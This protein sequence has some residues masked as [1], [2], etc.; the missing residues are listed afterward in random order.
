MNSEFPPPNS[1]EELEASITAMLLGELPSDKAFALGRAIEQ[2]PHLAESYAR[3]KKTIGLIETASKNEPAADATITPPKLTGARR[4]ELL[5][6]FKTVAPKEFVRKSEVKSRW[7][8]AL[9]VTAAILIL[10]SISIPN[11][12]KA[13]ST[14]Q[15]NAIINNL[16]Q[17]DG[18]K[19]QWALEHKK[20]DSDTPTMADLTPYLRVKDKSIAGERYDIGQVGRPVTAERGRMHYSSDG[21][22]ASATWDE[23]ESPPATAAAPVQT[24]TRRA[25]AELAAKSALL[26]AQSASSDQ[27]KGTQNRII[28]PSA[29]TEIE[30]AQ[31]GRT[32]GGV[33]LAYRDSTWN[34][35]S[36]NRGYYDDNLAALPKSQVVLPQSLETDVRLATRAPDK[37]S[38]GEAEF[39]G[40][41]DKFAASGVAQTPALVQQLDRSGGGGLGGGGGGG[42]ATP[43]ALMPPTDAPVTAPIVAAAPPASVTFSVPAQ[44]APIITPQAKM[45]APPTNAM[46]A[47]TSA[48]PEEAEMFRRRYGL[49]PSAT[50]VPAQKEA[51]LRLAEEAKPG[52]QPEMTAGFP[53]AGL[54]A[55]GVQPLA[56]DPTTGLP[57]AVGAGAYGGYGSNSV[58][59]YP[60]P[61]QQQNLY[62]F[63]DN[64]Q[65]QLADSRAPAGKP[66]PTEF[67][68]GIARGDDAAKKTMATD[69]DS[70]AEAPG[71]ADQ[72]LAQTPSTDGVA[73]GG[74]WKL[75][76]YGSLVTN[77]ADAIQN[78]P[79]LG[80]VGTVTNATVVAGSLIPTDESRGLAGGRTQIALPNTSESLGLA[81]AEDIRLRNRMLSES[82]EKQ[83]AYETA[84][85]VDSLDKRVEPA[86][87]PVELAKAAEEP[88]QVTRE[89]E[90]LA[91]YKKST[92]DLAILK[93][94][95]AKSLG[96]SPLP[97]TNAASPIPQPEIATAENPFSTFSLNVSDV[98]FKLAAASLEKGIMPDPAGIRSEEFINAFDYRDPE[99][100]PGAP[101]AFAFDRSQYP[102]AQNRDLLRLSL[103]T[104][105]QGRQP[106]RPLNLVLLLDNSGSMERA[107]R[108]QIIHE[109][110]RVLA[111][112]LQP[113]DKFSVITFA[114]TAQL[115]IDGVSGDK[116]SQT[117][118]QLSGLTPEGGTNLEDA[119]N[120]AYQVAHKYYGETGINR[121]VLLT[122]GAANL[123]DV[124][125]DSLKQKVEAQRKQGIALDCFGIGWEGF[126]D[127]LLEIL[128]RNGDG[129]YGF[130]NSP[131]QAATEFAG[132]LAGALQIAASDVKVQV[133][134][135]PARVTAYRQVGYAKHQL[136]KEQFRD[137]TIDAAELGSAESG[138]AIYVT[139]VKPYGSGPLA[140]VR[141]RYKVPGTH[142]YKE[143]EWTVPYSGNAVSLD[144]AAP[145][146]RL[147]AAS[148]AFSEWLAGSPFAG[149]VS[150]SRLVQLLNG[151]P[152]TYGADSRPQKLEWMIRQ[153]Q[154]LAGK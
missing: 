92:K 84:K 65:K 152:A 142:D 28:L 148:S 97:K 63:G 61:V 46:N 25:T 80:W 101:F 78:K 59:K 150:L 17:L 124:N 147:A 20:S 3:L 10:L 95:D 88:A 130:V 56:V 76:A 143:H 74:E 138:N 87:K 135:N 86:K 34:L 13:R 48:K 37:S 118:E 139:E 18:A 116:A 98:S 122:D 7:L 19:Q 82:K 107:D 100:A 149:D 21:A 72:N 144:Q 127:D 12:T 33:E 54:V 140:I 151:V 58:N 90:T 108:Q 4:Q 38:F 103:K 60:V 71:K 81:D 64:F 111:A 112:Q 62:A 8:A 29:S 9:A 85:R 141:V 69:F 134:F 11:F 96:D 110:L 45:A 89:V 47:I 35:D 146:M 73:L 106:G 52:A 26:S 66:V 94:K 51:N 105:S 53:V 68:S 32:A 131:E 40:R 24:E 117:T 132:Q 154:S 133:E 129:R 83:S 55:E 128:S 36:Q 126:N 43:L 91:R 67:F 42:A 137:N 121:V 57:V 1:R 49:A 14:S 93:G 70:L 99:P 6:R 114:R 77:A 23:K 136:T 16:R 120:L 115:R 15:A 30:V 75:R 41:L 79:N 109:A 125:P 113:Q 50:P 104:A 119:M 39:L 44:N 31:N 123:G 153:A 145:A 5:Q 22:V 27:N 2:D 102:F